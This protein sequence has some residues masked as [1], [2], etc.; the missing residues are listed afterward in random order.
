MA[1]ATLELRAILEAAERA[2]AADDF[3]SAEQHLRQAA[4]LQETQLGARHPDLANTLNNLGIVCEHIGKPAD[5]EACYRRAYRI[6]S[7]ALPAD[8]PLVQT[9]GQNLK[10][11]CEAIGKPFELSDAVPP[12][13]EPF[14]PETTASRPTP[15]S[16][17]AA[18]ARAPEPPAPAPP[19]RLATDTRGPEPPPRK[20]T[21]ATRT[22]SAVSPP[23]SRPPTAIA[24]GAVL[25]IALGTWWFGFREPSKPAAPSSTRVDTPATR[26]EPPP[27]AATA[28]PEPAPSPAAP[29]TPPPAQTPAPVER[30]IEKPPAAEAPA[31]PL[32]SKTAAS[33]GVSVAEAKLCRTLTTSNFACTPATNPS[34]PGVFFFYTRVQSPRDATVQHR[35]LMGGRLVRSVNLRIGANP[36]AGYRTYS[37]N[38][39]TAERRGDWTIEL[40]DAEGALLHEERFTVQ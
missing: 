5:A 4:A 28:A 3:V 1:E 6:A 36:G 31:K 37:R 8:H 39:V 24:I 33:G 23:S 9:S 10:D 21:E 35:W 15:P 30:P 13:L 18:V 11:F 16:R 19:L 22:S 40:R 12:E 29:E 2:A 17:P 34:A 7:A 20:P 38:T 27:P 14:A 32:A 25:L 26:E